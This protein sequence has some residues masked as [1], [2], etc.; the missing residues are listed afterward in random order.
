LKERPPRIFIKKTHPGGCLTKEEHIGGKTFGGETSTPRGGVPTPGGRQGGRK[1]FARGD[2]IKPP[3]QSTGGGATKKG[4]VP[5]PQKRGG[6]GEDLQNTPW[7]ERRYYY[8]LET[9]ET[10]VRRRQ[11]TT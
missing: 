5:P 7:G 4:V 6:E 8:H 2:E 3:T 11:P 10:L 9:R 1:Y